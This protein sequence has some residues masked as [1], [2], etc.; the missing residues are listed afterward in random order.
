MLVESED[1]QLLSVK[2]TDKNFRRPS[3]LM[4]EFPTLELIQ[5]E[6]RA[7]GLTVPKM[8]QI[9]EVNLEI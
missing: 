3:D 2:S 6:V 4:G 8:P 5:S 7:S 9:E 1:C